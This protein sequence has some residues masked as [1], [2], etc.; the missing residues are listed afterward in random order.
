MMKVS[1]VRGPASTLIWATSVE[2]LVVE[3]AIPDFFTDEERDACYN[4]LKD[5]Y[6]KAI[7]RI[8]PSSERQA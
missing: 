4:A 6:A 7:E 8:S 5:I 3:L 1:M 2:P